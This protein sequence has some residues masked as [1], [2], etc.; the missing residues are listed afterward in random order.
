[1]GKSVRT[2][3]VKNSSSILNSGSNGTSRSYTIVLEANEVKTLSVLSSADVATM[4]SSY[5][6]GPTPS[7]LTKLFADLQSS[8]EASPTNTEPSTI[9]SF[10]IHSTLIQTAQSDIRAKILRISAENC[11]VGI[12]ALDIRNKEECLDKISK[13]STWQAFKYGLL[14]FFGC[15]I[16]EQLVDGDE[17]FATE[18]EWIEDCQQRFMQI[19]IRTND[20]LKVKSQCQFENET[21][22][23][24]D[25]VPNQTETTVSDNGVALHVTTYFTNSKDAFTFKCKA[26]ELSVPSQEN[27]SELKLTKRNILS[28]VA[29][30]FDPIGLAA[31]FLIRAKIVLQRLWQQGL[32]WDEELSSE[33]SK[34]WTELFAEIQDLNNVSFPRNLTPM[35]TVGLP[36][37]CIFA[38]ASRDAI[39][40]CSYLRWVKSS[41]VNVSKVLSYS[42]SIRTAPSTAKIARTMVVKTSNSIQNNVSHGTSK[43]YISVVEAS[44]EM[45][46][47]LLSHTDVIRVMSRTLISGALTT[48]SFNDIPSSFAPTWT[49]PVSSSMEGLQ[50]NSTPIISTHSGTQDESAFCEILKDHFLQQVHFNPTIVST[51]TLTANILDLIITNEPD[52]IANV[53]VIQQMPFPSDHCPVSFDLTT[54]LPGLQEKPRTVYNFKNVDFVAMKHSLAQTQLSDIIDEHSTIEVAYNDWINKLMEIIDSYIPKTKLRDINTPPWIN[55]PVMHLVRKKNEARKKVITTNKQKEIAIYTNNCQVLQSHRSAPDQAEAFNTYIH[56][57]FSLDDSCISHLHEVHQ[58]CDLTA[59][60]SYTSSHPLEVSVE[61]VEKLLREIDPTKACGPDAFPSF[62]LKECASELAPSAY[63]LAN[64][65]QRVLVKGCTSKLLPV[66]SGVPQGSILGPLLFIWYIN[67]L[68]DVVSK[69]TLVY[70][71]ADDT[72][73]VR[74]NNSPSDV[75]EIQDDITKVS[76]WTNQWSLKLNFEKCESL[77]VTRNRQPVNSVYAINGKPI[78]KTISQKDLGDGESMV[79]CCSNEKEAA[80]LF[81]LY[82]D[83]KV[84]LPKLFIIFIHSIS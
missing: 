54:H 7:A 81:G 1:M 82:L 30:V 78:S 6:G 11:M 84:S 57:V 8:V 61:E 59:S 64:R 23:E 52:S 13:T 40:A 35:N 74:I 31:A 66:T 69:D 39:G 68:P 71:F 47:S 27:S 45:T 48:A 15:V 80:K 63:Y 50:N 32:D 79:L 25:L 4:T 77:S 18:E 5:S 36:T 16:L 22:P 49:N 65:A 34:C 56:S 20:Y 14:N 26:N 67:D 28:K 83:H 24:T 60:D 17:E 12:G 70:L 29:R 46:S 19:R 75:R 42:G 55:G 21:N 53:E 62:V 33:V 38:D 72:K 76:S 73:L 51:M 37:L 41:A 10:Q 43:R 3:G 58:T 9:P 2:M 44:G